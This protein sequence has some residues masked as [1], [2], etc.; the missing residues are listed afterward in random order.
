MR[1][2][3]LFNS[4]FIPS[5][6]SMGL[7]KK[8]AYFSLFEANAFAVPVRSHRKMRFPNTSL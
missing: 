8:A 4:V 7:L 5:S 1:H 3:R 6:V 2:P